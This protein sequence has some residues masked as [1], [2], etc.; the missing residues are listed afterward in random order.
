M[1]QKKKDLLQIIDAWV[2]FQRKETRWSFGKGSGIG[3]VQGWRQGGALREGWHRWSSGKVTRW[4]FR[5]GSG[6]LK[7]KEGETDGVSAWVESKRKGIMF[8]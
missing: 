1:L 7:F 5:R 6:M 4:S 3:G 8:G 2:E